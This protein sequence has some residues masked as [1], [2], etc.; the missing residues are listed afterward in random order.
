V[1][2]CPRVASRDVTLAHPS[3]PFPRLSDEGSRRLQCASRFDDC[4]IMRPDVKPGPGGSGAEARSWRMGVIGARIA[5]SAVL[6]PLACAIAWVTFPGGQDR[7]EDACLGRN[8]GECSFGAEPPTD[9]GNTAA[10]VEFDPSM[11]PGEWLL[12]ENEL[13]GGP[14]SSTTEIGAI[15]A[16]IDSTSPFV[17]VPEH[18]L[19]IV[20]TPNDDGFL[21][22]DREPSSAT[23][24]LVVEGAARGS[25]TIE[26]FGEHSFGASGATW[27]TS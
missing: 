25:V 10:M 16:E 5:F 24:V 21:V 11:C 13:Q 6:V 4:G 27:C 20:T 12:S 18:A 19:Q 7:S 3:G 14:G 9:D 17:G 23:F 8:P 26:R 1:T 2:L 22:T 15:V